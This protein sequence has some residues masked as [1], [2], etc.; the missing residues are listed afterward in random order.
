MMKMKK[1]ATLALPSL[2]IYLL[3]F[4]LFT[5]VC[6]EQAVGIKEGDWMEYDIAVTGT[7]SLPPT[8]DVRWM[9]L[10]ILTVDGEAFSVNVAVRY[11]NGTF[12]S[13]IW[14]FN[15]TEGNTGGWLIIPANLGLGDTFFDCSKPGDIT[16]QGEEQRTVL[17]ATR[18]VTYGSDV[19]R[20]HKEWDKNTGVFIG[21][22]EVAQNYTNE[23]GWYFD[24]LTMTIKATATNMW[25]R[26]I[27]GLEPSV[28]ALVI[29]SLILVVV[30][31]VSTLIIWQRKK[32][33]PLSTCSLMSKSNPRL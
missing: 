18:V 3:I 24:N 31:T 5:S 4:T 14:K 9:R 8:H 25:S 1:T 13:S 12:G 27:L 17:G 16:V 10:E 15:F 21:S 7:G 6:A 26:Q 11:A 2:L 20:H 33:N 28:F 22:V 19:I 30:T 23:N 32:I 29:S